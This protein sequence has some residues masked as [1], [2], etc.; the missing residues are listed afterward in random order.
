CDLPEIPLG[1]PCNTEVL[2]VA[3]DHEVLSRSHKC[4]DRFIRSRLRTNV[5]PMMA[6]SV[7]NDKVVPDSNE[8]RIVLEYSQSVLVSRDAV[9]YYHDGCVL[10]D[11]SPDGAHD[12]AG[13]AGNP[14][15]SRMR[16]DVR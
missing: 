16:L 13:V 7:F 5:Q 14:G 9:I 4:L 11:R 3:V 15:D 2:L 1:I 8:F 12:L 6:D 10:G